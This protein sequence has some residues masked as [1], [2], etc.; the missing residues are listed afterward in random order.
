M[1]RLPYTGQFNC[2]GRYAYI[3]KECLCN[4]LDLPEFY[5]CL[6]RHT[7]EE[8]KDIRDKYNL[9]GKITFKKGYLVTNIDI[10]A[11][12]KLLEKDTNVHIELPTEKFTL[13]KKFTDVAMSFNDWITT[14]KKIV[15]NPYCLA[16]TKRNYMNYSIEIEVE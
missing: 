1:E 7:V 13:H 3:T 8:F 9:T 14:T 12:N 4:Q 11:I 15:E 10:Q 5:D 16:L 6:T 2:N